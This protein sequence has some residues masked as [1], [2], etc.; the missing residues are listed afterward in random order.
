MHEEAASASA[1]RGRP[2]TRE[3]AQ[4]REERP[5]TREDARSRRRRPSARG[6]RTVD[7]PERAADRNRDLV[8][9]AEAGDAALLPSLGDGVTLLDVGGGRGVPVLQSLVLDRLLLCDGPAVW[10]DAGGYATTSALARV[11]PSRRLLGRIRVAR[12]FTAYQHYGA[13]CDLPA[14]VRGDRHAATAAGGAD[15]DERADTGGGVDTGEG[16]GTTG[17]ESPRAPALVVAP[18]VDSLYRADDGLGEAHAQTLLAR[19]L[20]RLSSYADRYDAPV[21]VTRTAADE[22]AG[23]VEAAADHRL[24]CEQTRFGPRFVGDGFET[25]VYP[26]D[27]G[28]SYQT[29][30]AYWRQVL[31][32]R[33]AQAGQVPDATARAGDRAGGVG[34]GVRTDGT[35]APLTADPLLDAWVAPAGAGG[36]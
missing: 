25:L 21:L 10:V 22:F 19:A 9:R 30:L 14:A 12:G 3:D 2:P 18:A 31:D 6:G 7:R 16:A 23:P 29:T 17:R 11:A 34:T 27:G 15:A 28:A 24:R 26:V 8:D 35:T 36:R 13:V 20:A 32:A 4:S 1:R 33:A 5:S